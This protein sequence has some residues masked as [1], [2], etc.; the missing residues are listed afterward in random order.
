MDFLFKLF[1][2]LLPPNYSGFFECLFLCDLLFHVVFAIDL[3]FLSLL[4]NSILV[5]EGEEIHWDLLE[6]SVT[7]LVV[8][9]LQH[10]FVQLAG[11]SLFLVVKHVFLFKSRVI[12]LF[13]DLANHVEL[14]FFAL[15]LVCEY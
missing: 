7:D 15:D 11:K 2:L 9:P 4:V 10:L 1:C 8:L 14:L 6:L 3:V 5:I 13:F 12:Q